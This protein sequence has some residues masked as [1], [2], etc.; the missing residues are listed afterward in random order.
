MTPQQ[1]QAKIE[2]ELLEDDGIDARNIRV[3]VHGHDVWL[4]GSVPTPDMYDYTERMVSQITG[5][6]ALTN[7][8]TTTEAPYDI[9]EHR[10]GIDLRMDPSTDVNPEGRL[11]TRIDPFGEEWDDTTPMEGYAAGGPV[12]GDT[13]EPTH[14]MDL[15]ETA[16]LAADIVGAEEP[17]R[18]QEPGPNV[19]LNVEPVLPPDEDEV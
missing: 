18:Y 19:R 3:V 16:P 10:E 7:S 9:R 8:L 13:G 12:G 14:P 5:I 15:S 17:W 1:L 6:E 11:M 2:E 4:E